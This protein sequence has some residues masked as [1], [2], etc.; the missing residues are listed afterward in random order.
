MSVKVSISVTTYNQEKYI[1][2]TLESL[3]MQIANFDFEI[4]INDDASSDK[5]Q[6]IIRQY[7]EKYPAI[8][9][10]I[11]QRENQYS[12]GKEVHYTFNYTR[13][14]GKYIAYCDGD[15]YWT[16]PLKLQ[17]Q[18]D[19]MESHS[20][21]SACVHAGKAVNEKG[22]RILW[23]QRADQKNTYLN[24]GKVISSQGMFA[25]NSLFMRNYF[26]GDYKV[27]DWFHEAKITDYPLYLI[28]STKGDLYY[29]DD[30]MCSFRVA[31]N[32]SFTQVVLN[33]PNRKKT[34][35]YEMIDLLE[36]FNQAT[37]SLYEKEIS[38]QIKHNLYDYVS[39][40]I[41]VI[42]SN[43]EEFQQLYDLVP[44]KMKMKLNARYYVPGAV[45]FLKKVKEPIVMVFK[46]KEEFFIES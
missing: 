6:D 40:D 18:F 1:E 19:F 25:S 31:S 44:L 46:P 29:M 39:T 32:G 42:K 17:K 4:L 11:Y 23:T 34:H 14:Q 30:I 3:L 33:D 24:T 43:P 9:K 5:S 36:S 2:Q 45:R 21:V 22:T 15:D 8:I 41:N 10:P 27:P 38:D 7:E 35:L 20:H 26:T 16:D 37:N 28:L 13:A 12:Q